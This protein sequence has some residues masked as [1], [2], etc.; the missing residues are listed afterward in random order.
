MLGLLCEC[1]VIN[2]PQGIGDDK[3]G[4]KLS[5]SSE[6]KKKQTE[7]SQRV[8]TEETDVISRRLTNNGQINNMMSFPANPIQYPV[9]DPI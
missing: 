2:L 7:W 8:F 9:I 6:T 3:E 5:K 1:D 4:E